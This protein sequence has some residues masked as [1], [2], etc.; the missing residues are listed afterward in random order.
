MMA[1]KTVP[2]TIVAQVFAKGGLKACARAS[3]V[4]CDC[5]PKEIGPFSERGSN[6]AVE[7]PNTHPFNLAGIG[8]T[9]PEPK[10]LPSLHGV[11][12]S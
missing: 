2:T 9:L 4:N 10:S 1:T 3:S 8:K 11:K 7:D 5:V 6:H 12:L